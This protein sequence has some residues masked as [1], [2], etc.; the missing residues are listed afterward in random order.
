MFAWSPLSPLRAN[1]IFIKGTD[2]CVSKT[3]PKTSEYLLPCGAEYPPEVAILI[4]N[5]LLFR[6]IST[7]T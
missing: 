1:A 6:L 5:V 7:D 2:M 3:E 4:W